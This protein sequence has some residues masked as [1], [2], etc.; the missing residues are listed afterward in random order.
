M[1]DQ[2]RFNVRPDGGNGYL[3]S[4]RG[5][6][7]AHINKDRL[8]TGGGAR[9]GAGRRWT[10]VWL[11]PLPCARR[12]AQLVL[13]IPPGLAQ[14]LRAHLARPRTLLVVCFVGAL[15]LVNV[16]VIT[17]RIADQRN[18]GHHWSDVVPA[19][20]A[21]ADTCVFSLDEI[22]KIYTWEVESGNYPSRRRSTSACWSSL[23]SLLNAR[24]VPAHV[25][26]P[27]DLLNPSVP[28]WLGATF[29][30]ETDNAT[31]GISASRTYIAPEAKPPHIAYP[32]RP[33]PGSIADL[34]IIMKYCDYDTDQVSLPQL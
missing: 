1:A 31:Q 10:S 24:A 16:V 20:L 9:G 14:T 18:K 33:V 26:V 21:K 6:L 23:H 17:R 28:P 15:V 7:G 12:R 2:K 34:D 32:P 27:H 11:V 4:H 19:T 8:T 3:P 29:G 5:A 30:S 25:G 22:R 13:P